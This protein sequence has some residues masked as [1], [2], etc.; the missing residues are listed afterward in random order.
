MFVPGSSENLDKKTNFTWDVTAF[1]GKE[2]SINFYFA[3]P[4]YI[5]VDSLIDVIKIS[6]HNTNLFLNPEDSNYDAIPNGFTI[7]A[8]LPPQLPLKTEE[9][10]I[11]DTE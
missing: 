7:T 6:F 4:L 3:N 8:E 1:N 9:F 2:I 11:T 5:S 10:D